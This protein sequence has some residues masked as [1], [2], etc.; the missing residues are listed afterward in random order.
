MTQQKDFVHL[1][2]HTDYSLLDGAIQIKPLADRLKEL[3]MKACAITDHGNIFGAISFY[4]EMKAN[5]IKPLIGCEVYYTQGSRK[6]RKAHAP[7]E[8]PYNHMILLAKDREG[9]HN[10]VKLTSRAYKEGIY[11]KPRIDRELLSQYS[12]GLVCLSACLSGVPQYFLKRDKFDEAAKAA[13]E[14]EDIFGKGN[15]FLEIQDHKLAD[16]KKIEKGLFELAKK[17][18]IPLVATNDAHYLTKEDYIAHDIMLCIAQSKTVNETNRMKFGGPEFYVRSPEEMWNIFSETPE[19][20]HR[21]LDIAE[22]CDL[23]IPLGEN[24]LPV[25]PIPESEG[26]ITVDQYFEKQVWEGYRKRKATV[27]DK[28]YSEGKLLHKFE[29][30]EQRLN[31]EIGIIKQMGFPSYFLI[32]WDFIKY[33]KDRNIP[34]GPG[35]G[36]LEGNVPIVLENGTT[37]PISKVEVGDYVRSHT[38]RALEVTALHRYDIDETLVR[39]KCYYGEST[40]VTLTKDHKILAERSE[41]SDEWN[42]AN[43]QSTKEARQ[44]WKEPSGNLNWTEAGE[45]KTGDWVF[46][47]TPKVDVVTKDFIDLAE[48]TDLTNSHL[49]ESFI[50]EIR[51]TNKP[52]AFSLRDV[53]YQTSVSRN[54]I[55]SIARNHVL[56][57]PSPSHERALATVEDY[58]KPQFG[59]LDTWR[60]WVKEQ[61]YFTT[62]ISRFIPLNEKFFR[63]LG[64][65]I[66]DGWL[67]SDDDKVLGLC[68]HSEDEKGINE[69]KDFFESIGLKPL[70]RDGV[71]GR[72]LTQMTVR[73]RSLVSY[74]RSIFPN[75][76]CTPQTKHIPDFVLRL[77]VENVI[78]IIAG[79]WSGDGCIG[80]KQQ[81]KFTATTV[82]RTLADQV[83]FLGWR[84][85]IPSSVRKDVRHDVRFETQP[86]YCVIMAKDERLAKKLN[87][88]AK[89]AQYVWR[90]VDDGILLR[91]RDVEE[92]SGVK[93][94]F[95]LTVEEDHTYQTS[96]F[97]VH[98]SAAGSMV[99]YCLEIT[100]VDPLQYNLL[101]ERFLNPERVSMPDI[102]I[103]FCIH[104]R[105]EVIKHVTEL[106]GRDSVCQIITFGTMAS[107]AAVKDVGRAMDMPYPEVEKIAKMIPP[108]VRGRNVSIAQ[109]IE[110]VS[111]LRKEQETNPKIAELL[112]IAQRLEGCARHSSVHAAGVVISP[113][114]LEE[115]IP[116]AVSSKNEITTQYEMFDLEKT[117]M[118]KM[119][120]LGLTTLTIINECL[121]SI[122]KSLGID[123]D[124]HN[125]SLEDEKVYQLFA[126]GRLDAVF[127]FESDGMREIC[128]RLQP[129]T[130]ED[131]SALN[132]LYR[133]GPLD[134]GMIDDY[135]ERHHGRKPIE[136]IVPEMEESLRNTY[137]ICVTGDTL[138]WDGVNG[139]RVRID[140]LENQTGRFYVQGVDENLNPRR[141]RVTNFICN[142]RRKVI[143]VKLRNGSSVK[144]TPNHK[145]L[146][147]KGWREIGE[148]KVGDYIATPR[149]LFVEKEKD[150]DK[151]K[152]RVL[153]YLIADGSLSSF[154]PTAD[155]VS[156]DE[157]LIEEY[158][159]CLSA[160]ERIVPR[161][162]QQVRNV[163]RVMVKGVDKLYYHETNSLISF[164]R[165]L[166]LK[167]KGSGCR[168]DEKFV[169]EFIF[170][171]TDERIAFFLAS[172]WDCDGYI[173]ERFCHYK[174]IS[175]QLA[176][177]VQTLLLRLGIHSAIYE[178]HYYSERR[179][180]ETT[181]YQ[182]SVYDLRAFQELISPHLVSKKM[183]NKKS[184]SRPITKDT[185]SRDIFV[186]DLS[187]KWHGTK[188]GLM[189]VYGFSHQHLLPRGRKRPRISVGLVSDL[190]DKLSLENTTR[191]LNVRWEEITEIRPAGIQTVYDITVEK[192]HNF[193]GNNVILHN[194]VYQEQIMQLSQKLADYS[195]G[196]ADLMRRAMGK[197]DRNEM[198]LHEKKFIDGATKNKIPKKKAQEIFRLMANFADYGFNRSHSIAYS[199][200]AFQT[201]YLKAHYPSHFYAAVLTNEADNTDKVL[202][203]IAEARLQGIEILPPDLNESN[204]EFKAFDNSI[205]FGLAAI[206]GLGQSAVQAMLEAREDK[207]F[208][209][210]FDFADRVSSKAINKRVLEGLI[211]AGAIDSFNLD[212][213]SIHEWRARLFASIDRAIEY[214]S[215]AQRERDLGQSNMFAMLGNDAETA[216]EPELPK[217]KAWTH[218]ELLNSEKSSL[219]FYISGHPLEEHLNTLNSLGVQSVSKLSELPHGA[220]VKVGGLVTDYLQRFTKKNLPYALFRIEDIEG[221]QVKCVM[222]S[223]VLSKCSSFIQN[224]VL[225]YLVGKLDAQNE[226][227][228]SIIADEVYQLEGASAKD[229]RALSVTINTDE[230]KLEQVRDA[231]QKHIGTCPVYLN[232]TLQDLSARVKM[233]SSPSFWIKPDKNLELALKNLGCEV[234]WMNS[235]PQR[236]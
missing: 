77:P 152:L 231:L 82:S 159:N 94:V 187:Q 121:K 110:Q 74:W 216:H 28:M 119:D 38:G 114:P 213:V 58:I 95:D 164:L 120:F 167:S 79:Y 35:R 180:G 212:G 37:K 133:P 197:K 192:I 135:I 86:S 69:A 93:E 157:K 47:P 175:H 193:V 112:E 101:F 17:T 103:D 149:R 168:S 26:D 36:C 52:F 137:G 84:C 27:M 45:L 173:G 170:A 19:V 210:L 142:G 25:F 221:N 43:A 217:V 91:I 105:P 46:V 228:I 66:A 3:N 32:V 49:T 195:L 130:L 174:T 9:Y 178:S 196:E 106:Y 208:K 199:L 70:I 71:N 189:K 61:A 24:Q 181:A 156:K 7:G 78:D 83:R 136:Y 75:Y 172:L 126:E 50:D 34:V 89:A 184:S 33:A 161:T 22:M 218:T 118:L 148:L 90:K 102:D 5:D 20:L 179:K 209:S 2:L 8:K 127:Q 188:R 154:A 220:R 54:S 190:S 56:R 48:L 129:R 182:V 12:K 141:S 68:F 191:N 229:A 122:K 146:T 203:Y 13:L 124:W 185:V 155:F 215:K 145:V 150:Y 99:A 234:E 39:L 4:K 30:Y 18:G 11:Y 64:R 104:G 134:S 16:Q 59:N 31:R 55:K 44:R 62:P 206:K 132:A 109:A 183:V 233:E 6:E 202:K 232:I 165:E 151:S 138:I 176:Q 10:L 1:H 98:N 224:D 108:P 60:G 107:K 81:D 88:H 72:K 51:P 15:Y 42:K 214:G 153:A 53:H 227:S 219:G 158:Q 128:R 162:L 87:A 200:V 131:L 139:K 194:C 166:G 63:I 201:A 171:L 147:E 40:G 117:G 222:W 76:E 235:I 113:K 73:S 67:R 160:F 41:R 204:S 23:K 144:L 163:T 140:Q 230:I 125:V 205:R 100:D 225:I 177:D 80:K 115:L 211:S 97:A 223:E 92:V 65:W 57:K 85:G 198:A 123:I 14:F 186:E 116:I 236:V 143:E 226:G 207:P 21:T 111:E 169:P 96:S 29:E